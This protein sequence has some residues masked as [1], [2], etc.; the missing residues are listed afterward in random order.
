MPT[1]SNPRLQLSD[2]LATG[3][4]WK[5]HTAV[6]LDEI[7]ARVKQFTRPVPEHIEGSYMV[8]RGWEN[9]PTCRGL[10]I[11]QKACHGCNGSGQIVFETRRKI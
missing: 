10:S 8:S 7:V 9:C 2:T 4:G 3:L 5:P 11:A 6:P 1:R